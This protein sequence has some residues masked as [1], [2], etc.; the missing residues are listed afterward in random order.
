M[1]GGQKK[2]GRPMVERPPAVPDGRGGGG[3]AAMLLNRST[4]ALARFEIGWKASP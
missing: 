2:G 3:Q 4:F 1:R